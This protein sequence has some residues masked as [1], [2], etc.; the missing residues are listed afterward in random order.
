MKQNIMEY[1]IKDIDKTLDAE[2]QKIVENNMHTYVKLNLQKE[3][4]TYNARLR[5]I[6]I[7]LRGIETKLAKAT[8][9]GTGGPDSETKKELEKLKATV[10]KLQSDAI[11]REKINNLIDRKIENLGSSLNNIERSVK[12]DIDRTYLNQNDNHKNVTSQLGKLSDQIRTLQQ[13]AIQS[14]NTNNTGNIF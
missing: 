9:N 3:T 6:D 7:Q 2:V 8:S 5:E 4:S 1:V 12:K 14:S 11:E 13:N 10:Q